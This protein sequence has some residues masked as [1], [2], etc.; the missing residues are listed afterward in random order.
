MVF[1]GRLQ[2]PPSTSSFSTCFTGVAR[3]GEILAV[4]PVLLLCVFCCESV[5]DDSVAVASAASS[6][7][8]SFEVTTMAA[9]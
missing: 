1:F 9:G 7:A 6:V 2:R 3:P 4:V 8:S 5:R